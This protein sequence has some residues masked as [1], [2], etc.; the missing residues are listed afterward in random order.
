MCTLLSTPRYFL[1]HTQILFDGGATLQLFLRIGEKLIDKDKLLRAV[2][3]MLEMRARGASQQE[4][5]NKFGIDRSFISRL[6]AL[7][8]VRKGRRIGL[9][10]FPIANA[11]EIRELAQEEGIDFVLVMSDEERWAF[12]QNRTGLDLFNQIMQLIWDARQCDVVILAGSDKRLELMKGLLDREVLCI[13]L[14]KSPMVD[15][16]LAPD[17]LREV[18]RLVR[19]EESQ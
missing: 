7:G 13:E 4:V 5:A 2:E 17:R 6:E 11:A 15:A 3:Q 14:G 19:E 10:A 12:V 1:E 8:E 9:V 18:V 16:Y